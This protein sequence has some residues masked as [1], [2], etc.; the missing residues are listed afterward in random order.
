VIVVV[1]SVGD[2]DS[3]G[4]IVVLDVLDVVLDVPD[5]GHFGH[6]GH[7]MWCRFCDSGSWVVAVSVLAADVVTALSVATESVSNMD[8]TPLLSV[9]MTGSEASFDCLGYLLRTVEEAS[10]WF[11]SF[12]AVSRTRVIDCSSSRQKPSTRSSLHFERNFSGTSY[13]ERVATCPCSLIAALSFAWNSMRS[14]SSSR[15]MSLHPAQF[16]ISAA[17]TDGSLRE[18]FSRRGSGRERKLYVDDICDACQ[19]STGTHRHEEV[20]L[21]YHDPNEFMLNAQC[22]DHQHWVLESTTLQP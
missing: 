17:R 14:I 12:T 9:P 20:Q 7:C 22:V 18:S 19:Y 6:F 4:V 5:E 3:D 16:L 8:E 1:L 10:S 21:Y 13:T 11:S 15:H 2:V